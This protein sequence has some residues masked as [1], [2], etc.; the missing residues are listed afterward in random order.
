[1]ATNPPALRVCFY[2][3]VVFGGCLRIVSMRSL[4]GSLKLHRADLRVVTSGIRALVFDTPL[5][6]SACRITL[7][8]DE[9]S[10][11]TIFVKNALDSSD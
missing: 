3:R 6:R 8:T 10:V 5:V 11:K 9:S 2:M 7:P 4:A 1:M